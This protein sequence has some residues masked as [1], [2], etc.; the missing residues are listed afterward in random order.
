[1]TSSR[2]ARDHATLPC[3]WLQVR[4]FEAGPLGPRKLH[5]PFPVPLEGM[6]LAPLRHGAPLSTVPFHLVGVVL[7]QGEIAGGHYRALAKRQH[8]WFG[9]DDSHATSLGTA[10]PSGLEHLV[11]GLLFQ[12]ASQ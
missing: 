9:F 10:I 1:M 7:H 6:R 3:L 2:W 11:Y 5:R 12:Q 8:R 4:R